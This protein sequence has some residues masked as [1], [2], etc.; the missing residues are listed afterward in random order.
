[1]QIII[2]ATHF[3]DH[4]RLEGTP[5]RITE[6]IGYLSIEWVDQEGHAQTFRVKRSELETALRALE[7]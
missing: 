1:M 2:D 4:K 6:S 5:K 3:I 7:A